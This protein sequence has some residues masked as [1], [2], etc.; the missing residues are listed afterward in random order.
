MDPV[1]NWKNTDQGKSSR[2]HHIL[3]QSVSK[4][5]IIEMM[6]KDR[7]GRVLH[8]NASTGSGLQG[9]RNLWSVELVW[10]HGGATDDK[11]KV[12]QQTLGAL[13][14]L[15][16]VQ[17]VMERYASVS[18]NSTADQKAV[19]VLLNNKMATVRIDAKFCQHCCKP[20][21]TKQARM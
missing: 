13:W 14:V 19:K 16:A 5:N 10:K 17:V 1:E 8:A 2:S 6:A 11:K 7:E 4:P 12:R 21:A 15:A 9:E 3:Q 20:K 18:N